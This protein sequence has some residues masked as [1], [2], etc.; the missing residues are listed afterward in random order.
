MFHI[1]KPEDREKNQAL[2]DEMHRTRYDVVVKQWGWEIPG[3]TDGYDK[4]QFDTD[5]T[6]YVVVTDTS[7]GG[8]VASSRLNPTTSPHMLSELFAEY[9]ELQDYPVGADV[10]ECSRFVIDRTLFNDPLAEF[11]IR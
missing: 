5:E 7:V 3:I 2:I 10:W 11:R 1:I 9:C 8:V 6:V 4:D